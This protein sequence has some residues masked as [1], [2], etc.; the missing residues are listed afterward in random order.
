VRAANE[1]SFNTQSTLLLPPPPPP[2]IFSP[3]DLQRAL[4]RSQ[5]N[6]QIKPFNPALLHASNISAFTISQLY[7]LCVSAR[8]PHSEPPTNIRLTNRKST[9]SHNALQL[10]II[11]PQLAEKLM[12]SP[13]L[14]NSLIVRRIRILIKLSAIDPRKMRRL[15]I[16]IAC[17][18]AQPT[19]KMLSPNEDFGCFFC[20]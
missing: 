1:I 11:I 9:S 12:R 15:L 2:Y 3:F 10:C 7:P 20:F 5:R 6:L 4:M 18:S 16:S 19:R 8:Q 13:L 17:F 14:F